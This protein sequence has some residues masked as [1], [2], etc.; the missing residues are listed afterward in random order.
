MRLRWLVGL[1]AVAVG[2]GAAPAQTVRNPAE[3]L[4]AKTLVYF[5]L[6]EPG[7]FLKEVAG[8]FEGSALDNVPASLH[9][10]RAGVQEAGPAGSSRELTAFGLLFSPEALKEVQRIH[11]AAIAVTGLA[12]P[13][14]P[15]YVAILLPGA[16]TLPGFALKAFAMTQ[17][18]PDGDVEGVTLYRQFHMLGIRAGRGDSA[19][20][21]REWAEPYGPAVA[22]ADGVSLIGSPAAVK[23][24]IRRIK[25]L[26]RGDTLAAAAGFRRANAE[27]GN[28]PG[29]FGYVNLP[30]LVKVIERQG[31]RGQEQ[32]VKAVE[33]HVNPSAFEAL[34]A[35]ATLQNGALRI[36]VVG[37]LDPLKKNRVLDVL[38]SAAVQTELLH[39]TPD[40]TVAAAALSNAEG[41]KRWQ[42]LLKLADDVVTAITGSNG[43]PAAGVAQL[44]NALDLNIANDILAQITDVGGAVGDPLKAPWKRTETRG[45][46][47]RSVREGPE[48]PAVLIVR[49]KDSDAARRLVEHV[50]PKVY[51]AISQQNLKA[52]ARDSGDLKLY[53]LSANQPGPLYYGRRDNVL[54]LGPYLEP[55]AQALRNGGKGKGLLAQPQVAVRLGQ[56]DAP[57]ALA[58]MDLRAFFLAAAAV[59]IVRKERSTPPVIERAQPLR[60]K[61]D[62]APPPAAERDDDSPEPRSV[63]TPVP[64]DPRTKQVME[65]LNKA[66]AGAEPLVVGL[67]RKPDRVT[68]ELYVGGLKPA[69]ARLTD[70][71]LEMYVQGRPGAPSRKA[72]PPELRRQVSPEPAPRQR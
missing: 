54:V 58:V 20:R 31:F 52:E 46:N 33:E 18:R 43:A 64:M 55:V 56:L 69:V 10:L 21:P 40:D 38:P 15:D 17:G 49:A 26:G 53:V 42:D 36:R 1:A 41:V 7:T 8:L 12:G 6:R 68:L 50:L 34:T 3:I 60:D 23:D 51:G 30:E 39:F 28:H 27:M 37:L 29:P 35:A 13:E 44:E 62:R 2:G 25:G 70:F 47:F 32:A 71:A 22:T 24:V 61:P 11:G 67:A 16:S 5:Q 63:A 57:L 45:R 14:G 9:K 66:L 4:P 65:R 48:V 19:P 59:A 72:A